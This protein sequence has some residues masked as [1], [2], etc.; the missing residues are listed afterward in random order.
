M[1]FNEFKLFQEVKIH[2]QLLFLLFLK[3][4]VDRTV[5]IV[6]CYDNNQNIVKCIVQQLCISATLSCMHTSYLIW[7]LVR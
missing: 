7:K 3:D 1:V 6:I 4:K 2:I 5:N